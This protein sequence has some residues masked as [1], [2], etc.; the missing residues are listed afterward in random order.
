[1]RGWSVTSLSFVFTVAVFPAHAG[2]IRRRMHSPRH[3][4]SV[5]RACGGDPWVPRDGEEE[6]MYPLRM[7]GCSRR[8]LHILVG[9]VVF[10]HMRRGRQK[11]TKTTFTGGFCSVD[12]RCRIHLLP[13]KRESRKIN[14]CGFQAG[15]CHHVSNDLFLLRGAFLLNIPAFRCAIFQQLFPAV[16][17]GESIVLRSAICGRLK[18]RSERVTVEKLLN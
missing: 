4:L 2:V 13:L 6:E 8:T 3:W 16:N 11:R 10:S 18:P 9:Y 17:I 7:Q 14:H 12:A 1:M 15:V 5:P